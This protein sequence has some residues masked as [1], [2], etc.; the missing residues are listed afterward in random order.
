MYLII[1]LSHKTNHKK[2]PQTKKNALTSKKTN[3]WHK[4]W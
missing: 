1:Y 4:L 3:P 2:G